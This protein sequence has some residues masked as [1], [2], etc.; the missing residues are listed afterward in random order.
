MTGRYD[1]LVKSD[2]E[3]RIRAL[4]RALEAHRAALY[5]YSLALVALSIAVLTR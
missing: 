3:A 2:H 5:L 1:F 4:E